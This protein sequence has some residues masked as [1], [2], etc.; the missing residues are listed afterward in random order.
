[1]RTFTYLSRPLC[2]AAAT[3]CALVLCAAM[4]ACSDSSES[5][6]TDASTS[7]KGNQLA[8]I[9]ASGEV[10]KEPT[11]TFPTPMTVQNGASL[12]LQQGDGATI[13]DGQLVCYQGKALQAKDGSELMNTWTADTPSCTPMTKGTTNATYHDLIVGQKVNT[14]VAF[15]V[16]DGNANGTSYIMVMTLVS[17]GEVPTRASGKAVSDVPANL[18]KVT[19][20]KDGK[21]SLDLDGYKPGDQLVSQTLIEGKGRKVQE[22]DSL[23]VQYTGWCIGADGKLGQFDSSWDRG[24]ASSFGLNEVISGWTKGLSGKTIGSQVLL[25]VPPNEGYGSTAQAKIPANSTLYFVVDILYAS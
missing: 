10:G 22:T 25:V 14:T 4:A 3:A 23:T 1:M 11:I 19:L 20:G 17:A 7:G 16:N 13:K 2:K 8:G 18:P 21:P 9:T 24:E 5:S 6:G 12:V 15:G